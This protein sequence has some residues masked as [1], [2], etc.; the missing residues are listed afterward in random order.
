[1]NTPKISVIIPSYNK[2]KFISQTLE[3]IVN[4]GYPNLE[5]IVQDG[6]SI[7]GTL[8]IIKA[9]AKKNPNIVKWESKKDNGQLDAINNGLKKA[10]GDIV[11]FINADD[12]YVERAFQRVAEAYKENPNAIWFTGR[13]RVIDADGTEIARTITWYKNLLLLINKYY[14]LL[15]TNYLM[16]PSVFISRGAYEKY[17]PFTGTKNFITEY[18]LWLKLGRIQMPVIIDKNLSG[19]RIE[20]STKTKRMFNEILREDERVIDKYSRDRFILALHKLHNLGRVFIGRF[21]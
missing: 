7:D 16:Q 6:G 5:V 20:P 18:D 14:L 13:G 12:A 8:E 21:I 10:T 1:M 2:V 4:Q 17:G 9:F 19:F 15:I 3:S 11:T